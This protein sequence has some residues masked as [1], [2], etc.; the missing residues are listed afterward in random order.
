M[1]DSKEMRAAQDAAEEYE[2]QKAQLLKRLNWALDAAFEAG[3][4]SE[5]AAAMTPKP[6]PKKKAPKSAG[7]K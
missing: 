5:R 7:R 6:Q 3:R 1:K 4:A 2:Y